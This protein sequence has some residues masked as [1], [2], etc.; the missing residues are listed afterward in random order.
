MM[1]TKKDLVNLIKSLDPSKIVFWVGAGIDNNLPTSLPLARD[2]LM[3]LIELTCGDEYANKIEEQCDLLHG[4]LPRMET[5]ISEIKLFESEL[6]NPLENGTV[7]PGFS[8]FLEA[9]PNQCHKILAQYLKR[10]SNIVSLNYGNTVSK[11]FNM[12]YNTNFPVVPRFDDEMQMYLYSD[13]S[14]TQGKIYHPHG[15]AKDLDTIGISLAEVK[16]VLSPKFKKQITEWISTGYCF[17]FLGY[18]CSDTLDI[19]PFFK[20]LNFLPNN[21]SMAVLINH[22][23]IESFDSEPQSKGKED[24]LYPFSKNSQI[25]FNTDTG[26][27]LDSIKLHDPG[28]QTV[29][30]FNWSQ[31][32]CDKI[33]PYDERLHKYITLGIIKVLGLDCQKILPTNWYKDCSYEL[34]R[35]H[36][37]VDYYSF[38]CLAD[39]GKFMAARRFSKKLNDD[40]LTKS[41]IY[42]KFGLTKKAAQVTMP[43]EKV[44]EHLSTLNNPTSATIDWNISTALNRNAD[45]IILDILR[46]PQLFQRKLEEHSKKAGIIIKCNKKI[47]DLGNDCV[48]DFLQ[49]LTA[50][51]YYGVLLMILENKYDDSIQYL[52]Q[53][54]FHYDAISIRSGS[55]KCKLFLSLVEILNIKN[56]KNSLQTAESHLDDVKYYNVKSINPANLYLYLLL[57][58]YYCFRKNA[59]SLKCFSIQ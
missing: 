39:A 59:E 8:S 52:K 36:W 46:H 22:S 40:N 51:R 43:V 37:Y 45:W 1:K 12:Q 29:Q 5:V 13:E 53:A 33:V 35:R 56:D 58:V 57:K 54:L 47:I 20:S 16:K 44:Y 27:F 19:N 23:L 15:V 2:L 9:P 32:F 41:D 49:Y 42:A 21:K 6:S 24:L 7:V 3:R 26:K 30:V 17:I 38:N 50:L 28:N 34:F 14:I 48:L 4:R 55:I 10:G 11:A 25:I 31:I 18:S